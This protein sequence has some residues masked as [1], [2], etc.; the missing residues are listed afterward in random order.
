MDTEQRNL[1]QP[2]KS[3]MRKTSYP[4]YPEEMQNQNVN[5]VQ[6]YEEP[7]RNFNVEKTRKSNPKSRFAESESDLLTSLRR[8]RSPEFRSE[9]ILAENVYDHV[10]NEPVYSTPDLTDE[11]GNDIRENKFISQKKK[12]AFV[13]SNSSPKSTAAKM[14]AMKK[15]SNMTNQLEKSNKRRSVGD[16]VAICMPPSSPASRKRN[17]NIQNNK[18]LERSVTENAFQNPVVQGYPNSR[19]KSSND[20]ANIGSPNEQLTI[21]LNLVKPFEKEP[22]RVSRNPNPN[23]QTVV[24]EVKRSKNSSIA[25]NF[26][27]RPVPNQKIP[28]SK[29]SNMESSLTDLQHLTR[30]SRSLAHSSTNLLE[31]FESSSTTTTTDN[32]EMSL[33][34]HNFKKTKDFGDFQILTNSPPGRSN[35]PPVPSR[36]GKPKIYG[37]MKEFQV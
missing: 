7:R 18:V 30:S 37:Q 5:V 24:E 11:Y 31:M 15:K 29:K 26:P 17:K 20:M 8:S 1:V 4:I 2:P 16:P 35:A 19:S 12:S 32:G 36:R 25:T 13:T 10:K 27:S 23:M 14:A 22:N 34:L 3:I 28:K 6:L 33:D 9:W 21:T